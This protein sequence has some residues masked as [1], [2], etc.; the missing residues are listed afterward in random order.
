MRSTTIT[1][2]TSCRKPPQ[3]PIGSRLSQRPFT[4]SRWRASAYNLL[5]VSRLYPNCPKALYGLFVLPVVAT[6]GPQEFVSATSAALR[7]EP[8]NR[9]LVRCT[10]ETR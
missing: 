5:A 1:Q 2:A 6:S 8:V 4:E 3:N 7:I 9:H 10:S